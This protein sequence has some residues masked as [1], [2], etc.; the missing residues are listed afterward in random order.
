MKY[1]KF[2]TMFYDGFWAKQSVVC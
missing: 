1:N 2:S